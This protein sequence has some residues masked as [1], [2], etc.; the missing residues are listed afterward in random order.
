[1]CQRRKN[2][3]PTDC[4]GY[5]KGLVGVYEGYARIPIMIYGGSTKILRI[6]DDENETYMRRNC[7]RLEIYIQSYPSQSPCPELLH[8]PLQLSTMM[9]C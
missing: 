6:G 8:P 2:E 7:E 5:V 4:D 9:K 3:L 1:M